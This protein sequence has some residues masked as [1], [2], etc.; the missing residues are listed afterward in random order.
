MFALEGTK[1]KASKSRQIPT[2]CFKV[3]K[4]LLVKTRAKVREGGR[5]QPRVSLSLSRQRCFRVSIHFTHTRTTTTVKF[6]QPAARPTWL[7]LCLSPLRSLASSLPL[8]LTS[9]RSFSSTPF[10]VW[11]EGRFCVGA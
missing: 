6:L 4:S 7:L 9:L 3:R 5:G 8:S 2:R 1:Q 10:C 11:G